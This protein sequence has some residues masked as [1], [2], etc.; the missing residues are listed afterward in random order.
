MNWILLSR[1]DRG[2]LAEA[3]AHGLY[4]RPADEIVAVV[5]EHAR[6]RY[7]GLVTRASIKVVE[8]AVNSYR[9]TDEHPHM[10]PP[11]IGWRPDV[12][13]VARLRLKLWAGDTPGPSFWRRSL[14]PWSY[15]DVGYREVMPEY[16]FHVYYPVEVKSGDKQ[17]L[18]EQQAE[19]IPAI[20]EHVD[21]VH[22]LIVAIE[23]DGLP[24]QYA[25]EVSEFSTSAWGRDGGEASRY[26][27]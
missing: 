10:F 22:P 15:R 8:S 14:P 2:R 5:K 4:E 7:P 6:E 3:I 13:L 17:T 20:V 27:S 9:W 23:L 1:R 11:D 18:T 21:H 24:G 16:S 25:I 26:R 12:V 19:A